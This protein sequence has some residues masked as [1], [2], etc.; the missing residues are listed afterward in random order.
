M[1]A[2]LWYNY[3][4]TSIGC[5]HRQQTESWPLFYDV[6]GAILAM[7][8]GGRE[9]TLWPVQKELFDKKLVILSLQTYLTPWIK[10]SFVQNTA[11]KAP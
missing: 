9:T 8:R 11:D 7:G 10:Q 6:P 2:A 1:R 3:T 4:Y 5:A